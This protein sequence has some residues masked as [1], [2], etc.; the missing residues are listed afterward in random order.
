MWMCCRDGAESTADHCS[1]AVLEI[2]RAD[3]QTHARR[4]L[5]HADNP[6][7]CFC[8]G[9]SIAALGAGADAPQRRFVR[10]FTHRRQFASRIRP[11]PHSAGS[12]VFDP[13]IERRRLLAD[14]AGA[15][16]GAA[17]PDRHRNRDGDLRR[18]RC[19]RKRRCRIGHRH[20]R[21]KRCANVGRCNHCPV[22]RCNGRRS[23]GD[24]SRQ[25]DRRRFIGP[26]RRSCGLCALRGGRHGRRLN[27]NRSSRC[28]RRVRHG[29]R[30][31]A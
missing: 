20:G 18:S 25:Y 27:S 26:R 15:Q 16:P 19:E 2:Q 4:P 29:C 22:A 28:R 31:D 9:E 23:G 12:C 6:R 7:R 30:G 21:R 11:P 13:L 1:I 5:W 3:C 24:E 14:S 17:P 8:R 10:R